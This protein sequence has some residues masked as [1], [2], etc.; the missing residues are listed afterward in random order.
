MLKFEVLNVPCNGAPHELI[1]APAP[2]F[3]NCGTQ[4]LIVLS[5][6]VIGV[7]KSVLGFTVMINL[8]VS[9]TPLLQT[10]THAVSFP[11]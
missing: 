9:Q 10:T 6:R 4:I 2:M 7:N 1:V 5:S 3:D 11:T 8:V